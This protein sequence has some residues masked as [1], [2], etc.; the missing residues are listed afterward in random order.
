MSP[1]RPVRAI[2][3]GG[4]ALGRDFPV[5]TR[6]EGPVARVAA[7]H[8]PS[9]GATRGGGM[10]WAPLVPRRSVRRARRS[11]ARPALLEELESRIAPASTV[12]GGFGDWASLVSRLDPAE[13]AP[14]GQGAPDT[15]DSIRGD[16]LTALVQ[17]G[18]VTWER[19]SG[20][21]GTAV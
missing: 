5:E 12:D 16:Q 1:D 4:T 20:I 8:G 11:G 7:V 6:A 3:R 14:G 17:T 18:A 19:W 15:A 9:A 21:P 13:P 2:W 10:H